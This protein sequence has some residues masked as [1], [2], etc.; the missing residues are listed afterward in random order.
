MDAKRRAVLSITLDTFLEQEIMAVIFL[1][2]FQNLVEEDRSKR[3]RYVLISVCLAV[4]RRFRSVIKRSKASKLAAGVLKTIATLTVVIPKC[5][6]V[7][8]LSSINFRINAF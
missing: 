5:C 8:L 3:K 7:F 6:S 2:Q 4:Y 1:K